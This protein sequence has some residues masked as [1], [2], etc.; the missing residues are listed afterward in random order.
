MAGISIEHEDHK[1]DLL[2]MKKL[3]LTKSLRF[4]CVNSEIFNEYS[5]WMRKHSMN[6]DHILVTVSCCGGMIGYIPTANAIK[7]G[8]YE[9]DGCLNMFG[10]QRRY[11]LNIE[12]KIMASF[13]QLFNYK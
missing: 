3:D 4:V 7:E 8:G 12:D 6:N 2:V 5:I 9:V 10:H 13:E 1:D 11:L